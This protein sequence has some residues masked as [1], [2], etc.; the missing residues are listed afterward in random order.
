MLQAS[1]SGTIAGVKPNFGRDDDSKANSAPMRCAL[2]A[3]PPYA[4]NLQ[5][6]Q[7]ERGQAPLDFA[8][9]SPSEGLQAA[10]AKELSESQSKYNELKRMEAL[11]DV[12]RQKLTVA[13]MRQAR[14]VEVALRA[15]VAEQ[16]QSNQEQQRFME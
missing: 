5:D 11:S 14:E 15:E 7:F 13:Q 4:D 2:K 1:F 6:D 12:E 8:L 9:L 16:A 10:H 3:P